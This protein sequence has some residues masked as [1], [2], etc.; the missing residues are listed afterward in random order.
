[1]NDASTKGLAPEGS[2]D[3]VG[4][5]PNGAEEHAR[6]R[7]LVLSWIG[8]GVILAGLGL[9]LVL[10]H[11]PR[12]E[13][14]TEGQMTDLAVEITPDGLLHLPNA[15]AFEQRLTKT[16]VVEQHTSA[17]VLDVTGTLMAAIPNEDAGTSDRWQF[18]TPE[19]LTTYSEWV[20][21]D[22]DVGFRSRALV[23]TRALVTAR[24]TAQT[25]V[26]DRL[27]KLVEVGSDSARDLALEEANLMQTKLEGDQS[28]HESENELRAAERKHTALARQLEQAGLA[29]DLLRQ[30]E[31]GKALLVAEIPESRIDRVREGIGCTVRFYGRPNTS[32]SGRVARVLPTV[33]SIQRTLRVVVVLDNTDDSLKPGMFA[34]VGLGTD[35][36][37]AILVPAAGVLHIGQ[38]DYVLQTRAPNDLE[39]HDVV[40]GSS[41]GDLVEVLRGIGPNA[42]V[43][44]QGAILLKAP[45][46]EALRRKAER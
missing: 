34:D 37:T 1:M 13:A 35:E 42:N 26:V 32:L 46:I 24:V 29:P 27:R 33:S 43:I 6:K 11:A 4:R 10:S 15:P 17:A 7:S 21:S 5:A 20:Q 18:A 2:S 31:R 9:F 16:D 39:V 38:N 8:T 12:P 30:G 19:L 25:K 41:R 14:V 28:L 22:A 23:S 45:V 44:G 36:R 3:H 40:V